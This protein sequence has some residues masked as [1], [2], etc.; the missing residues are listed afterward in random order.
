MRSNNTIEAFENSKEIRKKAHENHGSNQNT[1]NNISEDVPMVLD[2]GK[3]KNALTNWSDNQNKH[4]VSEDTTTICEDRK[5]KNARQD[6]F[7]VKC[8]NLCIVNRRSN[9]DTSKKVTGYVTSIID[10][11]QKEAHKCIKNE[12][13]SQEAHKDDSGEGFAL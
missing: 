4:K 13:K 1:T 5:Q 7:H 8:W 12:T 10:D 2:D 6:H 11:G 3:Q 9:V